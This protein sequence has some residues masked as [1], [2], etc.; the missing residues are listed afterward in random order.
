MQV[1]HLKQFKQDYYIR[2]QL[3]ENTKKL[4]KM[5]EIKPLPEMIANPLEIKYLSKKVV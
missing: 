5:I 3:D 2:S 1:T 4:L